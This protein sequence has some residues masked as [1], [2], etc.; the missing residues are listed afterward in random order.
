MVYLAQTAHAYKAATLYMYNIYNI[1]KCSLCPEVDCYMTACIFHNSQQQTC[2][3]PKKKL[4]QLATF[5]KPLNKK[6][7]CKHDTKR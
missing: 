2:A 3:P 5:A 6:L 7:L 1:S 4:I